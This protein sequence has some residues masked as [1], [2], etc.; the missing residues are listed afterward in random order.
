MN[1]LMM[2]PIANQDSI[3]SVIIPAYNAE[4][5][6]SQAIQSVVEQT[7]QSQEIIVADDGSTDKTGD[8]LKEFDH[9]VRCIYQEKQG[10][11]AA[12]NANIKVWQGKYICFLDADNLWTSEK[13]DMQLSFL[14]SKSDIAL[15]FSNHEEFN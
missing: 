3:V 10:P 4:Q 12:R 1:N 8:I 13:M 14:A 6:I 9:K 15:V 11:S 5:F 2:P 7:Y